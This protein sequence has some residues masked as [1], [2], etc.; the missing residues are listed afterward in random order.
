MNLLSSRSGL[1]VSLVILGAILLY[2]L[3]YYSTNSKFAG[4]IFKHTKSQARN[5]V[6]AFLFKKCTG[7]LVLGL[8]PAFLYQLLLHKNFEAFGLTIAHLVEN[9]PV[10]LVLTGII[11][12]VVLLNQRFNRENNS[13]QMNISEWSISL[14]LINCFG[15]G[16]YL[17]AY[18]FLFRGILLSECYF[19]F[20][21]WPAVAINVALNSA[22]HM[23]NGK[24]QTFG[25]IVFSGVACFFAL[26]RETILIPIVMH[27][28]LSL[29][30]DYFSIIYNRQLK[31]S[32]VKN[33][34][35]LK[36]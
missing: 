8:I 35:L 17:V 19:S 12:I 7:F 2:Y 33:T 11:L 1:N 24:D 4:L 23:V 9:L 6:F 36:K 15:W 34:N 5:E 27:V 18:E 32:E 31:F 21:F 25:A 16:I 10:I 13:L 30:S 20:G 28:S 29:F 3:Y 26:S 14:F 22:I